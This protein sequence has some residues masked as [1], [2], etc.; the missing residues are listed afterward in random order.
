MNTWSAW[1]ATIAQTFTSTRTPILAHRRHLRFVAYDFP[2]SN[3]SSILTRWKGRSFVAHISLLIWYHINS[4]I[5]E[6]IPRSL[7]FVPE[8]KN[9]RPL[10][11]F[12]ASRITSFTHC[13]SFVDGHLRFSRMN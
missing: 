12:V 9:R 11:I 10:H 3:I 6:Q 13:F 4:S 7:V 5:K 2:T 8:K 1:A